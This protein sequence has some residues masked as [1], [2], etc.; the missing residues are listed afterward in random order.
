LTAGNKMHLCRRWS[1]ARTRWRR[2]GT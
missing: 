1:L 2:Q